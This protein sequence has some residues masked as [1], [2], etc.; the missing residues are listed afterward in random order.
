FPVTP[1]RYPP[2]PSVSRYQAP[3]VTDA[4]PAGA[5]RVTKP[6]VAVHATISPQPNIETPSKG[7]QMG[8][9]RPPP[10]T[11]P[12]QYIRPFPSMAITMAKKNFWMMLTERLLAASRTHRL[13]SSGAIEITTIALIDENHA[14][15]TVS[16]PTA[17]STECSMN[18]D[19]LPYI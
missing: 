5:A 9:R 16:D 14:T 13:A 6:Y 1:E 2:N 11:A 12:A 17:R 8:A 18:S 7:I 15:G 19:Q 4:K 10:A 3:I